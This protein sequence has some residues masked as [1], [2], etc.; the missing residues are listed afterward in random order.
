[1]LTFT[2]EILLLL[3]D[4]DGTFLPVQR[5]AFESALAGAVLL[6]LAFAYRIDTDLEALVVTDPTPTD[7]PI[8]DRVLA[9]IANRAD[10]TDTQ[11]WIRDLSADDIDAV[12][13]NALARLVARGILERREER[14]LWVLRSVR[15]PTI[16]SGVEREI[17][18]RIEEVLAD[19]IP[20]PR[21]VALISLVDACDILPDLFP[22]RELTKVDPRIVQLRKMDLIGREVAGTIAEI[23]RTIIQAARAEAARFG[24]L[25]LTL[26]AVAVALAAATLLAPRIPIPDH[27][28]PSVLQRLWFDGSW[29]QWSGYLLVGLSAIGLAIAVIV[30]KRLVVRIARSHRWRL[31]HFV[32]GM[33]CVVVLF[34]HTGFRFGSN[35]NAVLMACYLAVLLSGGLS[36][37]A[38]RVARMQVVGLGTPAMRRRLLV[39]LHVVALC[40]LPALLIVHILTAY[41]Y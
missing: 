16:D 13:E 6:D 8:L 7:N 24:K 27:F 18:Q 10:T 28:G 39:R 4:K 9:K 2:E 23:Q 26:S 12:R 20:D 29:Q 31:T 34:A 15:Y 11:T 19:E 33:T 21:D 35:L 22:D 3:G 14:Y 36:E 40:P 37:V 5:Y 25:R 30:K 1:M 41:L 38:L 17:K 32:L